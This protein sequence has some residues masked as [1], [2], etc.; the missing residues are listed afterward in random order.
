MTW[1]E[2]LMIFRDNSPRDIDFRLY[3][4]LEEIYNLLEHEGAL[5]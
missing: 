5:K 1:D 4:L 3:N 2:F